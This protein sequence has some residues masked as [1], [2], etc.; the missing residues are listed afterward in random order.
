M[1]YSVTEICQCCRVNVSMSA[2]LVVDLTVRVADTVSLTLCV[3]DRLSAN[4]PIMSWHNGT[5]GLSTRGRRF[6]FS[7]GVYFRLT[8]IC[9]YL[10][11]SGTAEIDKYFQL[12]PDEG[13]LF[14]PVGPGLK[15]D[16]GYSHL[17]KIQIFA[18]CFFRELTWQSTDSSVY[19]L[20]KPLSFSVALMCKFAILFR[21][22]KT[23]LTVVLD[24]RTL[25]PMKNP[26]ANRLVA[27]ID[28][29]HPPPLS[30]QRLSC[31]ACLCVV[32]R[33]DRLDPG[34]RH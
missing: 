3:T 16:G 7:T 33:R 26:P 31:A 15:I 4:N 6:T 24:H 9:E 25:P 32:C 27:F 20:W 28:P 12:K 29:C 19:K 34:E 22:G 30:Q 8:E 1:V 5:I 13:D 11:S 18:L 14:K 17:S 21:S 10:K 23:A 2:A